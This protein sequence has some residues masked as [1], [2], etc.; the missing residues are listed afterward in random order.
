MWTWS[1][2]HSLPQ[3][4][5][6]IKTYPHTSQHYH[7]LTAD[8]A[9]SIGSKRSLW[10]NQDDPSRVIQGG[11]FTGLSIAHALWWPVP[12]LQPTIR[13]GLLDLSD[14]Y[15]RWASF[16]YKCFNFKS[17]QKWFQHY[18]LSGIAG[19]VHMSYDYCWPVVE[20]HSPSWSKIL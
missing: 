2:L 14:T 5:P 4:T 19:S 15:A 13:Q 20:S 16:N 10:H 7:G 12:I 9:C 1:L 17:L 18:S 3:S 11:C 6:S 8:S